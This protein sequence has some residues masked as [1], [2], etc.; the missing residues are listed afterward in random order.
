[1]YNCDES[2]AFERVSFFFSGVTEI[3]L[4]LEY[5]VM[6]SSSVDRIFRMFLIDNLF[7]VEIFAYVYGCS[8]DYDGNSLAGTGS[9]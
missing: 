6:D 8:F 1:M 3:V 9:Y 2:V 5:G 7:F 4:T